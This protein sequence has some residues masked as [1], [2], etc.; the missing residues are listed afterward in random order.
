M[1][2]HVVQRRFVLQHVVREMEQ[3]YKKLASVGVR[4]VSTGGSLAWTAYGA[5]A[6]AVREL[7]DQGTN[8]FLARALPGGLRSAAFAD[9]AGPAG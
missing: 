4:R 3:R 1:T 9:P 2:E 7:Q 5:L 6:E 8:T